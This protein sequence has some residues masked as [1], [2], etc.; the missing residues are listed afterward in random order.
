MWRCES[1]EGSQN[2]TT[3]MVAEPFCTDSECFQERNSRDSTKNVF[4]YQL[5][6]F[7]NMFNYSIVNGLC[8]RGFDDGFTYISGAASSVIDYIIM[9]TDSRACFIF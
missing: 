8:D 7:C 4:G 3:D 6:D 5:I 1:R 2:R 9:S